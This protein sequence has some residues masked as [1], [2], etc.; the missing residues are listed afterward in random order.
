MARLDYLDTAKRDLA[1]IL[2]YIARESGS[3]V[4]AQKFVAEL[5]Q[6]CRHLADLPGTMG[7]PR[8]ELGLGFRSSAFRGYVIYFRYINDTMEIIDIFEGHR[9]VDTHFAERDE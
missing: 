3:I 4:I 6:K 1:N 5:R 8:P 7:R 9:D 2:E